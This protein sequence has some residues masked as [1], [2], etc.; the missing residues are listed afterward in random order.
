[1]QKNATTQKT[2]HHFLQSYFQ[3]R[4]WQAPTVKDYLQV[5]EFNELLAWVLIFG[6]RPN[7]FTFSIHL[8]N[9]F[10]NLEKFNLFIEEQV[11][12]SLSPEGGI[13][14]GNKQAGIEQSSTVGWTQTVELA[15]GFI[16]IPTGFVE[17]V[18]RYPRDATQQPML[19]NDFFTG[20]VA[21]HANHVIESLYE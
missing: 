17:F 1:M 11:K 6:R 8:L 18:W 19:W 3:G 20:F 5:K 9:D 16:S 4:E 14:K 12:L 7:H 10:L 2:L 15:D 13:I 21:D